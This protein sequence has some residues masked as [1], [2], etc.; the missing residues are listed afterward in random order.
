MNNGFGSTCYFGKLDSN[1]SQSLYFGSVIKFDYEHDAK[2][3]VT[4][5][6]NA[7]AVRV[8]AVDRTVVANCEVLLYGSSSKIPSVN[9]L[10][11]V[12]FLTP[13]TDD[14]SG[15]FYVEKPKISFDPEKAATVSFTATKHIRSDGTTL[16]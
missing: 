12:S 3:I 10:D 2:K 1:I 6:G 8:D 7:D 11:Y 5:N 14:V 4:T 9:V 15:S 16:P 13:W